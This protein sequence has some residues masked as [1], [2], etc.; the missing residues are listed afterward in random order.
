MEKIQVALEK[1]RERRIAA[2]GTPGAA[3]A[4]AAGRQRSQKVDLEGIP[5]AST[6]PSHLR[7][8]RIV[9]AGPGGPA[10]EAFRVLRTHVLSRLQTIEGQAVAV[11]SP[12]KQDGKTF[13]SV[14]LAVAL[15]QVGERSAVLVDADLRRPSVAA[16]L[17]LEPQAGLSDY[18]LGRCGLEECLL[19]PGLEELVVLPQ[20]ASVERSSELL[21]SPAMLQLAAELKRRFPER[22]I[23]YDCPPLLTTD[24]AL[25]LRCVV[26]GFLIVAHEG[27]TTQGDLARTG[28]LIGEERYLGCVLNEARWQSMDSYYY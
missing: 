2:L 4:G 28:E 23:V 26:D 19:R 22:V 15:A 24:D 21:G 14:N 18:L 6:S 1:A 16:C 11:T 20:T 3:G 12:H 27:V 7:R 10:L 5:V 17:G 9:T 8:N 13:V 25:V